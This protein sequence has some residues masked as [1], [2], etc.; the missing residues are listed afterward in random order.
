M[1]LHQFIRQLRN[2]NAIILLDI[3]CNVICKE[4]SKSNISVDFY[5]Y[6]V[7]EFGSAVSEFCNVK[8]CIFIIID[9]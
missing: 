1:Q 8:S 2:E 5:E 6:N 7:V 4:L 9:K 3:D